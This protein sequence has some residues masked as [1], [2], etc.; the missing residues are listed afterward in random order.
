MEVE[1]KRRLRIDRDA[2]YVRFYVWLWEAWYVRFY[3]WLWE[4]DR[5]DADFCKLFW[6]LLLSPFAL[7]VRGVFSATRFA[8]GSPEIFIGFVRTLETKEI[9]SGRPE[10]SR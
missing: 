1:L 4:A 2:W 8:I 3:V 6:G 7:F 9:T 5:A 10:T